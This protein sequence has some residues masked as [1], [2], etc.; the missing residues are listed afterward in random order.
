MSNNIKPEELK[1]VLNDYLENYVEDINEDVQETT[2]TIT[3]EAVQEIKETSPRGKGT[4]K[5]PYYK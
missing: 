5:N 1:K 2:D 4:R 3:K